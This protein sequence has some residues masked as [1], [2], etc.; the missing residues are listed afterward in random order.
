MKNKKQSIIIKNK[1]SST[2]KKSNTYIPKVSIRL[3]II[4]PLSIL[5]IIFF[6]LV[7]YEGFFQFNPT[8]NN[9]YTGELGSAGLLTKSPDSIECLEDWECDDWNLCNTTIN[10]QTR[11]CKDL[12]SCNT[13]I[14]KPDVKQDCD[15]LLINPLTP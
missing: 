8:S 4:A 9:D 11:Y 12:N 1:P 6:S 5:L 7:I 10:T 3:L 14:N 15:N 13:I 2:S